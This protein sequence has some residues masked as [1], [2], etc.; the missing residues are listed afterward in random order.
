MRFS[1]FPKQE[2]RRYSYK[3]RHYDADKYARD[4]KRGYVLGEELSGEDRL[5][6]QMRRS[7]TRGS[8]RRTRQQSSLVRLVIIMALIGMAIYYLYI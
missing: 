6:I 3:P 4:E 8:S 2:I 5:R 7:L 1:F